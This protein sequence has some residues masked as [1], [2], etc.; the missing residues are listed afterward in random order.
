[1]ELLSALLRVAAK[2]GDGQA[3]TLAKALVE[4][5]TPLPAGQ[6]PLVSRS[7]W[8]WSGLENGPFR[9]VHEMLWVGGMTRAVF[10]SVEPYITVNGGARV[11]I[12]TACPM[13]LRV[14]AAARVAGGSD[15]LISKILQ[16]RERGGIFKTFSVA[17][18]AGAMGD[19][20]VLPAAEQAVVNGM[21]PF[22]T[23]TSD[24]FRGHVV[25]GR[26]STNSQAEISF[27]WDRRERRFLYWHED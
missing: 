9:S 27:V 22:I 16:F 21:A 14:L 23:V 3:G 7:A 18:L 6:R 20:S 5:R 2:M 26:S 15:D 10:D 24:R 25:A 17:G 4:A 13:V 19:E 11:N 12:N 1:V 8:T